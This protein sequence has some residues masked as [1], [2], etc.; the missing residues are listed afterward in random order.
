MGLK[1]YIMVHHSLTADGETVSWGAIERFHTSYRHGGDIITEQGYYSLKAQGVTGLEKPW[2]D[3]GY[4]CGVEQVDPGGQVQ[5]LLGRDWLQQ[6][7]AC[8]QGDM[9]RQALHVCV[10]GNY[11]L[12][13]PSPEHL[14]VLVKRVIL[15]W[16]RMF[17]IGAD[18]IVGHRDYNS[19]KT[20]PGTQFDLDALRRMVQ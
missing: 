12:V 7:A 9:N 5:A 15:P 6:A 8:P 1:R 19:G 13:T 10:V 3:I 20:C 4:G 17:G 14:R 16:M 2:D 18:H 11:D